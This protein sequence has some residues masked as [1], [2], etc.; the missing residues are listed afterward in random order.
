MPSRWIVQRNPYK[1]S[2]PRAWVSLR[3]IAP[4]GSPHERQL[5]VDTGSPCAVIVS[6]ADL[7][8]LPCN[9]AEEVNS[10]FGA[11]IGAWL[12]LDVPELGL[13]S[14]VLGFGS[15][16]VM[17]VARDADPEFAGLVGLPLLRMVEYGGDGNAF[18]LTKPKSIT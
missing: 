18:W 4:D 15:D 6:R 16:K 8:L 7:S 13:A 9:R 11:L 1:G 17:Q 3:F 10:N 14:E 2:P 12:Q 5:L